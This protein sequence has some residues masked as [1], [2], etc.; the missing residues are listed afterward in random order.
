[1]KQPLNFKGIKGQLTLIPTPIDAFSPLEPVAL[2]S[3]QQA[4]LPLEIEES[5]FVHEELREARRRWINWGLPKDAMDHFLPCHE[6]NFK[7][8]SKTIV[9]FLQKGK[10]VF[11]MSDCGLP[12]FCDPG[13]HLIDLCHSHKIPVTST[14]FPNSMALAVAL[15][16]FPHERF[17]FEGFLPHKDMQKRSQE[18]HRI[19]KEPSMVLLLD[20]PYRLGKLLKELQEEFIKSHCRRQVFL[21]MDLNSP[22]E[23]LLRGEIAEV[24]HTLGEGK[25]REFVLILA[26]LNF[27]SGKLL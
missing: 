6:Q 9:D 11:L 5:V 17:L 26:P 4:S 16:G 27:I 20:T 19:V 14:P 24:R 3:L 15:S 7:E 25:K 12:A 13:Q 8:A 18:I 1:M 2:A 10:R 23:W 22:E 21:A